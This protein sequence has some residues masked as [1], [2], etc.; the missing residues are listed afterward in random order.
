MHTY[1]DILTHAR[2]QLHIS[3][4]YEPRRFRHTKEAACLLQPQPV[5]YG[6]YIYKCVCIYICMYI[7]IYVRIHRYRHPEA[8]GLL[9]PQPVGLACCE[10]VG[11][12]QRVQPGP[13]AGS[14][15]K[16]SRLHCKQRSKCLCAFL[17]T[18]T[19]I[20][21]YTHACVA[22]H[23][24]VHICFAL[25]LAILLVSMSHLCF[26][27]RVCLNRS[28]HIQTFIHLF[29]AVFIHAFLLVLSYVY[30]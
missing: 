29:S 11:L 17:Y 9:L 24:Y 28:L 16:Q 15:S 21:I 6:M 19:H 27:L 7:Y 20:H 18:H 10:A 23:I 5:M 3:H 12:A 22:L 13:T 2:V 25:I 30:V 14:W 8:A 4:S 1:M 26:C